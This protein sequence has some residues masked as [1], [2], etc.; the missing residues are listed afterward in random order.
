V[1]GAVIIT[2]ITQGEVVWTHSPVTSPA[3]EA[4]DEP[5]FSLFFSMP[6]SYKGRLWMRWKKMWW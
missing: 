3:H 2:A 1:I 5:V 4:V 6:R